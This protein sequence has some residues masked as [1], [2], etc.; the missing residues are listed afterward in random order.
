MLRDL[1][2]HVGVQVVQLRIQQGAENHANLPRIRPRSR[3]KP[4]SSSWV[5]CKL[6][7]RVSW[8][9]LHLL[10]FHTPL[11][12][13]F[14]APL[15]KSVF[16]NRSNPP[17]LLAHAAD[18]SKL[19]KATGISVRETPSL[20]TAGKDPTA[21]T[22]IVIFRSFQG[23]KI[24]F[25]G[26]K[27]GVHNPSTPTLLKATLRYTQ[28]AGKEAKTPLYTRI[29]HHPPNSCK[30]RKREPPRAESP[31]S[32]LRSSPGCLQGQPSPGRQMRGSARLEGVLYVGYE[33]ADR[34][35]LLTLQIYTLS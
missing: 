9:K 21:G 4:P 18:R 6:T 28:T 33:H 22:Y 26:K 10:C 11:L 16:G 34:H 25:F 5:Y 20:P 23:N 30:S 7:F 32:S 13:P 17:N 8:K 12:E 35:V 1:C 19:Q 27:G 29:S 24:S 15:E 31:L 14:D 3:N 2:A